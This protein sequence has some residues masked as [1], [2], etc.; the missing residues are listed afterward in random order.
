MAKLPAKS[1]A[2]LLPL[3]LTLLMTCI[4]SG[5]STFRV[6]GLS[7][8]FVST[9]MASWGW[10]WIVAFPTFMVVMPLTR[11]LVGLIV[12]APAKH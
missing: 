5:I 4:V 8:D 3:I 9:W 11:R 1:A 12:H 10:S 6:I 2:L 7:P